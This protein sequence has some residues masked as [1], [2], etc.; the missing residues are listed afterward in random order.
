MNDIEL[1]LPSLQRRSDRRMNWRTLTLD[2]CAWCPCGM[3][4]HAAH[5]YAPDCG[6]AI[7]VL[8]RAQAESVLQR[9]RLVPCVSL[10]PGTI[11]KDANSD[12]IGVIE[13]TPLNPAAQPWVNWYCHASCRG[14]WQ[15]DHL[16]VLVHVLS[17]APL[18]RG[19]VFDVE[20][21]ERDEYEAQ[22][23]L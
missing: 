11:V 8:T 12:D 23:V 20:V 7:L 21:V 5:R 19:D 6:H 9:L 16:I 1:L 18:V 14:H 10:P 22:C 3:A 17:G 15:E 2:A 13:A 4:G